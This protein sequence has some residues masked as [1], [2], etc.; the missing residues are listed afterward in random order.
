MLLHVLTK[1]FEISELNFI[2]ITWDLFHLLI[3]L[4]L[5]TLIPYWISFSADQSNFETSRLILIFVILGDMVLSLK[6]LKIPLSNFPAASCLANWRK[7]SFF[8]VIDFFFMISLFISFVIPSENIFLKWICLGLYLKMPKIYRITKKLW[9]F[10]L[11]LDEKIYKMEPIL[12]ML[13]MIFKLF[14]VVH[15]EV[16]LFNIIFPE[17]KTVVGSSKPFPYMSLFLKL[18]SN[19]LNFSSAL[20]VE[21]S[22]TLEYL[23]AIAASCVAFLVF[24]NSFKNVC[25]LL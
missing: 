19:C 6:F 12:L 15:L 3:I 14:L 11:C 5:L 17:A 23:V 20:S 4:S 2:K 21:P 9:N 1:L 13:P 18:L 16:C 10:V 7:I 24:V 25:D 22:A 8:A